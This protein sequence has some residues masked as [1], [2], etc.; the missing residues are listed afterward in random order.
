MKAQQLVERARQELAA[1]RYA[2]ANRSGWE[3]VQA[4]MIGQDEEPV[5]QVLVIARGVAD[6][7]EGGTREEA[8]KLAT[9]CA[10]LLEGVGGGVR[11]PS[12][13]DRLFSRRSTSDRRRCPECAEDIAA[14]AKVCR[15]CGHRLY[16][17]PPLPSAPSG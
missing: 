8:E 12:L 2:A 4:A 14:D 6:A 16:P 15:Y 1:G 7:A 10:A 9:Y 17:D 3:A 5:R 13:I 11:A